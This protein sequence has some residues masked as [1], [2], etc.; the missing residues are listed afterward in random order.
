[1]ESLINPN[2]IIPDIGMS[3]V[4]TDSNDSFV[5]SH[6]YYEIFY[7]TSGKI[8]HC[9]NSVENELN[10]GSLILLRPN[11]VHYFIR[12][13]EHLNAVHRDILVD[14]SLMQ[15]LCQIIPSAWQII[16]EDHAA[17]HITLPPTHISAFE[18][19]F[20]KFSATTAYPLKKSIAIE[21]LSGLLTDFLTAFYEGGGE[22]RLKGCSKALQEILELFNQTDAYKTK[23]SERIAMLGYSQ[24][25]IC[26]LFKKEM[27]QTL[28]EYVNGLKMQRAAFCLENTKMTVVEIC[29]EIGIASTSYFNRIFQKAYAVTPTE[30]RVQHARFE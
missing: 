9:L 25:Y 16:N 3:T 18:K 26:R 27:G 12:K 7:M 29:D 14:T 1:M 30:N 22:N 28:T 17:L 2:V 24:A 23:V 4:L 11:D 10:T 21:I 15:Q 13:K 8:I 6:N 20:N 5:H 19:K